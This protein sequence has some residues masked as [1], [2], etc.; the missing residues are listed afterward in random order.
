MKYFQFLYIL[1]IIF[2]F[3][4][5]LSYYNI[6]VTEVCKIINAFDN[7]KTEFKYPPFINKKLRNLIGITDN[8]K[9]EL[10]QQIYWQNQQLIWQNQQIYWQNQQLDKLNH[11]YLNLIN[12][13]L[14]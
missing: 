4:F 3:K 11:N 12:N 6:S 5:I 1:L 14:D 10:K 13:H 7:D 9:N 2:Y 8:N